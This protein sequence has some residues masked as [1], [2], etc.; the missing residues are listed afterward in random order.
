MNRLVR[1][2]K[3]LTYPD[4]W[5]HRTFSRDGLERIAHAVAASEARHSAEIRVAIETRLGLGALIGGMTPRQRAEEAFAR[6]RVW[7]TE[8]NNGVLIYVLLAE[9]SFEIVA[10]RGIAR[11]VSQEEWQKLCAEMA[12]ML[13]EGRHEAALVHGIE[14]IGSRFVSLFPHRDDDVNELPDSPVLL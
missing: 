11:L 12:A 1:I 10:D 3:H 6:L 4:W 9:R 2:F 13:R 7:D 5:L 14:A 8:A